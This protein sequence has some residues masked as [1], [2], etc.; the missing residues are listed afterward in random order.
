MWNY[1]TNARDY[2][3]EIHNRLGSELK[4]RRLTSAQAARDAG[5]PDS[6]GLR[7]VLAGRKR[8]SAELLG[9]L[10]VHCGVDAVYVLTGQ[11]SPRATSSLSAEEQTLVS[12]F[13]DAT[14]D[15]QRVVMGALLGLR[16][17]GDTTTV[18]VSAPV[19]GGVAGRDNFASRP[20]AAPTGRTK[21]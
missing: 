14:K 18:T 8:L 19:S 1:S 20:P 5:L 3:E 10:T 12:Y 21:K 16:Q 9:A 15:V 11:H 6:Q 17:P 4:A 7:D 13:R 2:V